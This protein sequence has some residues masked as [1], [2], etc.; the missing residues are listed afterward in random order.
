MTDSVAEPLFHTGPEN[1]NS[2]EELYNLYG[3]PAFGLAMRVLDDSA[4]AEDAV[5]EVFLRYYSHPG[6]FTPKSGPFLNW[7]LRQVHWECLDRLKSNFAL[8]L[9]TPVQP[10]LN[11][12]P[13]LFQKE[14]ALSTPGAAPTA[15]HQE[16]ARL[17]LA[18]LP[19]DQRSLVE[20]AYFKGLSHREIAEITGQPLPVVRK[21]LT[22][23]L[24]QLKEKLAFI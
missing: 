14:P 16:R 4:R 18:A 8:P 10:Y 11:L 1:F 12:G 17:A 7:L 20:L 3:R 13:N 15:P 5:Q 22:K 2:L 6:T 24:F 23:G 9:N 19:Q 21:T